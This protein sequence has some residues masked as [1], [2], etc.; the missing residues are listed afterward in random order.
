MLR[1]FPVARLRVAVVL[2][3]LVVALLPVAAEAQRRPFAPPGTTPDFGPARQYDLLHRDLDL[4]LDWDAG[5]VAGTAVNRLTPLLPGTERITL[6]AVGLE[7]DAVR[8]N[9]REAEWTLLPERREMVVELGR[10][11][12]PG[13][14]VEVA[15]D[16]AAEPRAGLYFVGADEGYP[17]KPKQVWSQGESEFNRHW[18][19]SW[20]YPNDRATTSMAVTVAPPFQ[21][22]SNGRLAGVDELPDGRRTYRWEMEQDHVN[23]LVSVVA[24]ELVRIADV[25]NDVPVE[26]Y[27]PPGYEEQARRSFGDTPAM[28]EFFSRVIDEPYPYAK[29]AQTA[30]VDFIWGGMENIT[31]TTQ[32]LATLHDERAATD[33]SSDGLVAHELAHQWF[34]DLVT[35]RTWAH[36]WLNEGFATYFTGLWR[37]HDAGSDE[38]AW[39][40][41]DWR[42]GYFEEDA[43]DYRRPIVTHRY[44]A[45]MTMFDAHLYEK[46]A[47]VLHMVRDLAGDDGWWRG[48]RHYVDEHAHET[49]TTADLQS[50]LE[51]TTGVPLG[52]LF[53]QFVHGAGHPELEVS[54]Q[55]L[56]ERGMVRLDVAQTQE[57]TADTGL[58]SYPALEIGLLAAD[59]AMTI[60][61]L[62]LAARAEQELF[63][64]AAARPATVVLD[65]RGV[66]L[67]E[68]D[69]DKPLAEWITQLRAGDHL[70]ARLAAI[71]AL[72]ARG[73]GDSQAVAALGRVVTDEPFWG[74][75]REA[76]EALGELGGRD[77][78][79]ALRPALD[80]P[81]SRVR[82]EAVEAVGTFARR[83]TSAE[84]REQ[85]ALLRR[86]LTE[87]PSYYARAAAADSLGRY[88]E[89]K[90][91]V[92]PLLMRALDQPSHREVVREAALA[93]LA[94]LRATE[95]RERIERLARYGAPAE[96]R[97]AAMRALAI[98]ARGD[99]DESDSVREMLVATARTDGSFSGRQAAYRALGEL[100][101]ARALPVLDDIAA[102]DV[103]TQQ[104]NAAAAAAR[105]LRRRAGG[106]AEL[107]ERVDELEAELERLRRQVSAVADEMGGGEGAAARGAATPAS[108]TPPSATS[109]A[110]EVTP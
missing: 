46:G 7:V 54:W 99:D 50:A 39:L 94:R 27:V 20:D 29:Y 49:V 104:R 66:F 31:A 63:V 35:T 91:E 8:V 82:S 79:N 19:P 96:S 75:R 42:D 33:V 103:H 58:F 89:N 38:F 51:T 101:D 43:G 59:G 34:G 21:V 86:A 108:G 110:A 17:D 44:P 16:Y 26:Y 37:E 92:L 28:M 100:G 98:L 14:T 48:I 90:D 67:A 9:G 102:R 105:D 84:R 73:A 5:R 97:G 56:P 87:E 36:A 32:T 53:E 80:D 13:E 106:D 23:Y 1:D 4:E 107:R 45:P 68:V 12:A 61:E 70:P 3:P 10:A 57:V 71:R 47:L 78:F 55:W 72:G 24:G 52:A 62:P 85:I 2:L 30:A 81:E 77:A 40:V 95:A 25:W 15:V 76:A 93:S 6:H 65:P 22:V 60:A 18:F 11:Y 83:A 64:A 109:V 74:L 88:S 41:A 69:F